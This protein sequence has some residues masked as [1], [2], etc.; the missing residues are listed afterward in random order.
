MDFQDLIYFK[1]AAEEKNISRAAEKLF[2]SQPALSRTISRL[3]KQMGYPLFDRQQYGISLTEEGKQFLKHAKKILQLKA[4]MDNEMSGITDGKTGRLYL[5]ISHFFSDFL[6]PKALPEFRRRFPKAEIIVNTQTS[7]KLEK[8]IENGNLDVAVLV[9]NSPNPNLMFQELFY[10]RILLA[11]CPNS[12]LARKGR[13]IPGEKY[14]MLDPVYLQGESFILSQE[15]MRLRQSAELFFEHEKI[16]YQTSVVTASVQTA[17]RLALYGEG[18]AFIPA[19]YASSVK[20]NQKPMYFI[21]A[22]SLKDW[23]VGIAWREKGK[24]NPILGCFVES[25]KDSLL[26]PANSSQDKNP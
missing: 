24:Q 13:I 22:P 23:K 21:S 4:D 8:M 1:T 16:S 14:P 11:V 17:N 12:H 20:E 7:S 15:E 18:I 25:F 9:E 26:H 6:L 3:E 19:T 5:G 2:I 10:E